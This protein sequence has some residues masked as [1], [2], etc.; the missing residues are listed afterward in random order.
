M[1]RVSIRLDV[2]IVVL[3]ALCWHF[4]FRESRSIN[5]TELDLPRP[6]IVTE[7]VPPATGAAHGHDAAGPM[8]ANPAL[9]HH[10]EAVK[11]GEDGSQLLR[12]IRESDDDPVLSSV[13]KKIDSAIDELHAELPIDWRYSHDKYMSLRRYL[14]MK[15]LRHRVESLQNPNITNCMEFV[16]VEEKPTDV[17]YRVPCVPWNTRSLISVEW[18]RFGL[19]TTFEHVSP[20]PGPALKIAVEMSGHM[21]TY[22]K[23]YASTVQHLLEPNNALLFGVTYPD[24][25]DKR[26]GVR[27]QER[28]LPIPFDEIVD[29]YGPYLASLYILDVPTI[30]TMLNGVFPA[31]FHLKQWSWMIYQLFT[32]DVAHDIATA[33]M[34]GSRDNEGFH[35]DD[36][37]ILKKVFRASTNRHLWTRYD[38]MI[39]I[40]PDLYILGPVVIAPYDATRFVFNFSCG[41]NHYEVPFDRTEIIRSPHHPNYEWFLDK[42]SDHSAVGF[43]ETMGP[44]MKLY[45]NVK[46]MHFPRQND[47]VFK[48]GNTAERMWSQHAER[49]KVKLLGGFGWHIMLRNPEKFRNSTHAIAAT[50]RRA[51]FTKKVFGVTDPSEVTCPDPSGKRGTIAKKPPVKKVRRGV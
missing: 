21:R 44:F 7:L 49:V 15:A 36:P 2:L 25:G 10:V 39:R 20:R 12:S 18:K 30:T 13:D 42:L 27:E 35:R 33:H 38:V 16:R 22:R 9:S 46:A 34:M 3:L 24:V 41:G 17:V 14:T 29:M 28:D 8:E 19:Y 1:R 32:M 4:G 51:E 50:K 26:F 6:K 40:R 23:C 43:A 5:A 48:H 37:T 31:W 47:L 11:V 45:S